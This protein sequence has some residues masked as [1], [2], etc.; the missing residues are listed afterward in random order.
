MRQWIY[1]CQI[2]TWSHYFSY[3]LQRSEWLLI[4]VINDHEAHNAVNFGNVHL[5]IKTG[6]NLWV[7][8]GTQP[9]AWP[10]YYDPEHSKLFQGNYTNRTLSIRCFVCT[11]RKNLLQGSWCEIPLKIRKFTN[12][13]HVEIYRLYS[14]RH[15]YNSRDRPPYCAVL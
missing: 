10:S 5:C 1:A 4:R 3:E 7:N 6:A 12:M 15:L 2:H 14:S 8:S 11:E 9:E 13:Q